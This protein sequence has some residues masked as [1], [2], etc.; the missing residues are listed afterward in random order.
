MCITSDQERFWETTPLDAMTPQQWESLCDG[1]AKCCLEK[2]EDEDTRRIVYTNVACKLLDLET[3]R[4]GDYA[5][6]HRLVPSCLA[7]TTE[8][9]RDPYWLPETC[10]YRRLTEKRRLPDWHPLISGDPASVAAAGHS[11]AGRAIS[12]TEVDN[13]EWH[14]ID[15]IS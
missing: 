13:L 2:F 15:W 14:L 11:L 7:L 10:A 9:L 12:E 3:A 8:L 5:H 4:C 6:R 1:C